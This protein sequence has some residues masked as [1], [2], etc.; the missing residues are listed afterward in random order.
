MDW[1]RLK[2]LLKSQAEKKVSLEQEAELLQF[3]SDQTNEAS[4]KEMIKEV[5]YNCGEEMEI[6]DALSKKIVHQ[7]F[8]THE[9]CQTLNADGNEKIFSFSKY[10]F[11]LIAAAAVF[12]FG[13]SIVAVRIFSAQDSKKYNLYN[14]VAD[15][16]APEANRATL[17][18]ANGEKL[19]LDNMQDG[20]LAVQGNTQLVKLAKGHIAYQKISGKSPLHLQYN[21]LSNPRG[22][23]VIDILLSD[24]SRIWINAGSSITYPI[25]FSG[26]ERKVQITGELYFEIAH[27]DSKPFIVT[28]G[29]VHIEVLGTHF[30]VNTYN[31]ETNS[32]VTL[33]QGKVKV[34]TRSNSVVIKPG[35]QAIITT[36]N[37]LEAGAIQ[38]NYDA[39]LEQAIAWK[40]GKFNF[41]NCDLN[42]VLRQLARWYDLQISYEGNISDK[43]FGGEI[44]RSLNLSQIL[45]IL[46]KMNVRF[47]LKDKQLIVSSDK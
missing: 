31:D 7:I 36:K 18:L 17:T 45:K 25:A 21:T 15:V 28:G 38:V 23:K 12:F 47:K 9:N 34:V 10:R 20:R 8:L 19:Y 22:S 42:A 5:Y 24:G 41:D 4:I 6:D 29:G 46:E 27:D 39:D 37:T 35:Q 11:G 33:I 30:N 43:K 3:L 26:N 44:E 13:I 40:N 16:S 2:Y 14:K 32:K 1:S